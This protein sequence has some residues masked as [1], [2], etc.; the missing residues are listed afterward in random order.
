MTIEPIRKHVT[1]QASPEKAFEVF[2]EGMRRWWNPDYQI[3]TEPYVGTV[4]EPRADG[5]WF[6]RGESGGECDWGRVL[7]WEPPHRLVLEWQI[8][9]HG[10]STRTCTPSSRCASYPMVIAHE[11]SWSTEGS[12]RWVRTP[13]S[14]SA[15]STRRRVG[16]VC[17]IG[18]AQKPAAEI[19]EVVCVKPIRV[20]D[21][22]LVAFR[23]GHDDPVRS[24]LAANA[25]LESPCAERLEAGR[26][27]VDVGCLDVEVHPVLD[28]LGFGH[29]L[30]EKLGLNAVGIDE[31]HVV[32]GAAN[33]GVAERGGPEPGELGEI[34][35]VEHQSE[36]CSH[37]EPPCGLGPS[38][39]GEAVSGLRARKAYP[40]TS[41][42]RALA[43]PG[44]PPKVS[45]AGPIW[46]STKP[47]SSSI[48]CQPS[49][50]SP[51]AIQPVHRSM[52]R[53]ASGGTGRPLAMS[54][55]CSR[56]P[57]AARA[58]SLEHG[59]LVGAQ[60]DDAVGD[61]GVGPAVLDGEGFGEALAELDVVGPSWS[62]VSGTWSASRRSCRPDDGT[63]R[64]RRGGR[65]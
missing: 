53:I 40:Y 65:R 8:S 46:T 14:Y 4:V 20:A 25:C 1:V 31:H 43:S 52:S 38:A 41:K 54:A 6:E 5:R 64:G 10:S 27:A 36:R 11:S 59:T 32:A 44:A 19:G 56:R 24:V 28:G 50:G 55:N 51:P 34:G 22:E 13:R 63:G 60:V 17:S 37:V 48:C 23:Y 29:F 12:S 62:A 39:V 42:V 26:F 30:E 35:A 3:G 49:R 58:G 7:V 61:H 57:G 15:S 2:T 45:T 21:A 9:A 16:P 33:G 18:S 47:T